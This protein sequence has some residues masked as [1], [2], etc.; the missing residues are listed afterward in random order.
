[1]ATVSVMRANVRAF[2]DVDPSDV[3]DAEIARYLNAAYAELIGDASWPFLLARGQLATLS[4]QAEYGVELIASDCEAHRI[5]R[6]QMLGRDLR[7]IAA[8]QYY[9]I[10]P[11]G[12]TSN[13]AGDQ[14]LYWSVLEATVVAIWPA[15]PDGEA[16]AIYVRKP[17]ELVLDGDEPETP[18]RYDDLLE[19]G[20]V[21]RTYQKIGDIESAEIKKG[22]FTAAVAAVHGGLLRTQ[23]TSPLVFG[24]DDQ[25]PQLLPPL[26]NWDY[27][28]PSP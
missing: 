11:F 22:E 2:A 1:V 28:V 5:R 19:T 10:N 14:P 23:E 6:L 15:P 18:I 13:T 26:M 20:A 9:G 8:E 17:G 3:S 16:R 24:G 27:V 7:Y 12:A 25:P 21:A 4:G